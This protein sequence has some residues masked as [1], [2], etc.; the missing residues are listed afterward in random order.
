MAI[1]SS[2]TRYRRA[3]L[4]QKVSRS[5]LSIVDFQRLSAGVQ[6]NLV[7]QTD[8]PMISE[9]ECPQ[10]RKDVTAGQQIASRLRVKSGGVAAGTRVLD[11]LV[12][13]AS[14]SE[15]LSDVSQECLRHRAKAIACHD[16][17][18]PYGSFSLRS[19]PKQNR[20]ICIACNGAWR[21][22]GKRIAHATSLALSSM[23]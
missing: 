1:S 7:K 13:P 17:V 5:C 15:K 9:A 12:A 4:K 3:A 20:I 19:L 18:N 23:S 10:V 8:H 14:K 21:Q 2:S 6:G 22:F 11:V 16:V